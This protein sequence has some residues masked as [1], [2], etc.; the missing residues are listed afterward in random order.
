MELVLQELDGKQNTKREWMVSSLSSAYVDRPNWQHLVKQGACA[1]V[2][3]STILSQKVEK[4][5]L[6]IRATI[7]LQ[8][9]TIRWDLQKKQMYKYM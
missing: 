1:H 6:E 2:Y 3:E 8:T 4:L 7:N 5:W 9:N